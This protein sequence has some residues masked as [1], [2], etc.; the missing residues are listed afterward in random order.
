MTMASLSYKSRFISCEFDV[1]APGKRFG[2]VQ[3]LYSD[4]ESAGRIHLVPIVV[5]ANGDGPTVLLCAGTHGNEDE[6]QL[7]LRRLVHELGPADV[8]GRIIVLPALNYPAECAPCSP[9]SA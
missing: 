1:D 9:T 5:I 6:G 3:I 4:N 8:T 2:S 7:A